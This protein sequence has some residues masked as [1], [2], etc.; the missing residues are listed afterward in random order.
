MAYKTLNKAYLWAFPLGYLEKGFE[1]SMIINF[2]WKKFI[3]L[4]KS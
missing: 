1:A 3:N 4:G 2:I